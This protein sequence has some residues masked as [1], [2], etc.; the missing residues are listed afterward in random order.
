MLPFRQLLKSG[1]TFNWDSELNQLFEESKSTIIGEI[2]EGVRIFDKSKPTCLATDWSKSGIGSLALSKALPMSIYRALLLPH[3][4]EN[5]A[6]REPLHPCRRVTR[7]PS[8]RRG[9]GRSRCHWAAM[10]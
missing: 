5:N 10:T 7:W 1:T 3:R 9:P 2:E 8:R 4:L 6:R